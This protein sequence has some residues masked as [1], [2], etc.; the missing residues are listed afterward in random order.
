MIGEA[1]RP[2]QR[3]RGGALPHNG[4]RTTEPIVRRDSSASWASALVSALRGRHRGGAA[5]C[6]DVGPSGG[7]EKKTW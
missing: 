4:S 3:R 1:W 6:G 2:V 7:T 5:P